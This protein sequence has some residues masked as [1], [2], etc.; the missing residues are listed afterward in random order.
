MES[1]IKEKQILFEGGVIVIEPVD[2]SAEE[3]PLLT[4]EDKQF[5]ATLSAPARRAQW[6]TARAILRSL[7][8]A[9]ASLRYSSA[10]ALILD[11]PVE[12]KSHVSISH[13]EKWV[14]VMLS[15]RRCG[16]DIESRERGFSRVAARYIA[17]QE[18]EQFE[19]IVGE[20]FEAI[21]WC[22]KEALYKY[23]SRPGLDFTSDMLLTAFD[24]TTGTIEADLYGLPTPTLH[25]TLF[26]NHIVCY[27]SDGDK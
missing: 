15:D 8:G 11:R 12:G 13:T 25:Y 21:V 18:R 23:G 7:L 19:S 10:G 3:S 17:H 5:L 27:L 1:T 20:D 14:A 6:S 2:L 9:E 16:I 24:P 26:G 22:A 4:E